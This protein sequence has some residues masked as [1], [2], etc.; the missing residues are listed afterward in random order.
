MRGRGGACSKQDHN[1]PLPTFLEGLPETSYPQFLDRWKEASHSSEGSRGAQGAWT[2]PHGH[3][4]FQVCLVG[5]V[6]MSQ[7]G[8]PLRW[9]LSHEEVVS[10]DSHAHSSA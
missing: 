7:M 10:G 3:T 6:L 5:V 8:Q 9:Q 4:A 1:E 2:S